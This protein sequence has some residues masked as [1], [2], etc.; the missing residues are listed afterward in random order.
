VAGADRGADLGLV[1]LVGDVAHPV[2]TIL[3][4]VSQL[5]GR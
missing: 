1:F 4:S 3:D 2:Q 5:I